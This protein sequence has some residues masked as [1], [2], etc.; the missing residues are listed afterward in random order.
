M[1]NFLKKIN[2][3]PTL[4]LCVYPILLIM[5][6]VIF[7]MHNEFKMSYLWLAIAT[8][9]IANISIGVGVHRLWAHGAFKAK[10]WVQYFLAIIS[11]GTMQGPILAW[12][13]DH[14]KHHTFTDTERDPHTP[15]KYG[16]K[17]LGF[18]WSHM[19]WMMWGELH[20][21]QIDRVTL[22]K[23]GRNAAVMWQFKNYWKIAFFMN[24][25]VPPTLGY[26]LFG[27]GTGALAAFIFMGLARA[28]QQ[29]VTFCVNSLCHFVGS[30]SYY[31]GTARDIWWFFMFLLG[32][33]WHNFHHAFARDYRNGVKWYHP[34]VH[35]WIIAIMEKM[36]VA[37]DLVRTPQE[38]IAAKMQETERGIIEAAKQQMEKALNRANEI[39]I[40]ARARLSQFEQAQ[41][42]T[43]DVLISAK[44][45]LDSAKNMLG[46]AKEEA[47][48]SARYMTENM[49]NKV[50]ELE[51][52]A[53]HMKSH[54][55]TVLKNCE[56]NYDL[57]VKE[58]TRGVR[59]LEK[60][61]KNLGLYKQQTVA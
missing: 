55:N 12:S 15:L 58:A 23:L 14:H 46:S 9:Y 39:A 17:L 36:G 30:R 8:Y 5:L 2:F 61:A 25:I 29:Q 49:R 3:I 26:A 16:N 48:E 41:R 52:R 27:T 11:A 20:Y 45:A 4:I 1:K 28:L 43:K 24:V 40:L 35:K 37:S 32:E 53:M 47:V 44:E 13:S 54:I 10:M 31:A 50:L 60:F 33:N 21:K 34:D 57:A 18:F 42:L 59:Q 38:R 7:I 56:K 6:T 22:T 51:A 19:G